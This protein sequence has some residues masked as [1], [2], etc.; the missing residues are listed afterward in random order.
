MTGVEHIIGEIQSIM[1]GTL[2]NKVNVS[3]KPKAEMAG[4][5]KKAGWH[6]KPTNSFSRNEGF[7]KLEE[8]LLNYQVPAKSGEVEQVVEPPKQS[9]ERLQRRQLREEKK[10]RNKKYQ[11]VS[12]GLQEV[13]KDIET[14]S[15]D[16]ETASKDIEEASKDI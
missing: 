13:S 15:K 11:E 1:N 7:S 3:F 6:N 16:I 12:K 4:R 5:S 2:Q 9:S 8:L 14:V 10:D